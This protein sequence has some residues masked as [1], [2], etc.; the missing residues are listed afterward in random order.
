M[1]P[2][3]CLYVPDLLC[4]NTADPKQQSTGVCNEKKKGKGNNMPNV[5][6]TLYT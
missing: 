3:G 1:L 2:E 4:S 5:I 6:G